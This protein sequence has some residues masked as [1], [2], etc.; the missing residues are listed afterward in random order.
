MIGVVL[1]AS[2][3]WAFSQLFLAKYIYIGEI[4]EVL[5]VPALLDCKMNP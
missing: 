3:R 5:L 4:T 1:T 2:Q